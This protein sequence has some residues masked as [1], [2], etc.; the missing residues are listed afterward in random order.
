MS[1][2]GHSGIMGNRQ[3]A[4]DCA[5]VASLIHMPMEC[6]IIL[7]LTGTFAWLSGF[8]VELSIHSDVWCPELGGLIPKLR[9][10]YP[11]R[12]SKRVQVTKRKM[13][14]EKKRKKRRSKAETK[15]SEE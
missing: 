8:S 6:V 9:T 11:E 10:R 2:F 3:S 4:Y 7:D 14:N 13:S 12:N 15:T 1:L 5:K